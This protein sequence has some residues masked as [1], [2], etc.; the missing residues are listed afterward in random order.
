[1][2][3]AFFKNLLRD[4]TKTISRFLSIVIIIAVGVSFYVGIRAT[5]PDMKLSGDY[6]FNKN[7]L[8]DFKLISTLGL[9]KE[10]LSEI[11][12]VSGV[13]DAEGSYSVDV[14]IIQNKASLVLNI[15]S[16]PGENGINEI[17]IVQGRTAQNDNEAVIEENFLKDYKLKIGDKLSLQ[18]GNDK[19]LKDTLKKTEFTIVGTSKSPLYVS[20]QRQLSSVG[21]GS[22]RGFVYIQPQVFKNEEFSEIYVRC[23]SDVSKNSLLNNDKYKETV[24]VIE[25]S[26]KTLGVQ[27]A[28]LRYVDIQNTGND[29][30]K[31]AEDKL[32]SSKADA[33]KQFADAEAKL[34]DGRNK[35]AKGRTELSKNLV[36]FNQTKSAAEIQIAAARVQL[37]A[38]E[39]SLN[40]GKVHAAQSI[41]G[42]IEAKVL[43][44]KSQMEADPTNPVLAAQYNMLNQIYTKDIKGK[45]FENIYSSLKQDGALEQINSYTG[46][47]A[48]KNNF[49]EGAAQISS[50]RQ[51]L[52]SQESQLKDGEAKLAAAKVQLDTSQKEIDKNVATLKSEKEKAYTKIKDA[53][54]EI[55]KGKDKLAELKKPDFYALGRSANV[56]YETY[57]QDSDRIDNIGKAFP[58]IFFLVSTLV[59]LTTMTRMVQENRIE[60][61]TFKA[62]GYSRF[63]IVSHYLIYALSA[64]LLGSLLGISFGFR[65]FPPLILNAY[66]SL[67]TI[68]DSLTPFNTP[69]ALQ[70]SLIAILFTVLAAVASTLEELREVPASLMRPKPPKSGKKIL[71]ERIPFIWRKLSFTK[72]VT[73]RNLFRYKQ[74]FFM[75]VIGIAACTGLMIT[76]FALK[77]AISGSTEN[78][79]NKI[80]KYDMQTTMTKNIDN[81]EKN[82]IEDKIYR[83]SN[84]KSVLFAYTKNATVKRSSSGTEDAHII[85]PEKKDE[86]NKYID[87]TIKDKPLQLTDEG[88]ILTQK[89]SGLV[90]KK[91]GDTLELTVNDKAVVVKVAAITEHYIQHYIYMSPDYYRKV[92]G[93]KLEYNSFY[94]L[95]K[96]TSDTTENTTSK[97]LTSISGINSVSFKNNIY[98]DFGKTMK[99]INSVVLILI[100]SAG[101][102][103]FV[104]IFNLTNININERKR[105][106]ATIKLLGFYN[107]ELATYIY[108]ENV[109]LT[110]VGSFAGIGAG[111]LITKFVINT[112][113]TNILMF[114]RTINPIYYLY[115]IVITIIFSVIVNLAMYNRFDK[116]DMIESLKSAE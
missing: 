24:D 97:T 13:T 92:T 89:F 26:L 7:N 100:L 69:L 83:D 61:G 72:K 107:S 32:A 36:A 58:L 56:G 81:A 65:L 113:E 44:A 59:S 101:V 103:V 33:D 68:P 43:E 66:S 80:Y 93:E 31:E 96:D 48:L 23:Q 108:R 115:S 20:E 15:N 55:Q 8:M 105:E 85:V 38:S 10:D 25:S 1:M 67:Y 22:V 82:K 3:K 19:D 11:K 79:F 74:R 47:I 6:Y 35:L 29:K 99:S 42:G 64:S 2:N 52:S 76:G 12:K 17:R 109:I 75:T 34:Q 102:L 112:A 114:Y 78:Q 70:A 16:M 86:L 91:V 9:T 111:I 87:L 49:D 51:Q 62:I 14:V 46:I 53:E 90:G 98:L 27:R 40:S 104:V 21:N 88:V 57:R 39:A 60:I 41:S 110:I 63:A 30:I 4:I 54:I 5:S 84:I 116:I 37:D 106:L 50:H 77:G 73:A 71:L 94:G 18:S 95:L 28:E 45:D